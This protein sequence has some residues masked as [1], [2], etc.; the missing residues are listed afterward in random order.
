MSNDRAIPLLDRLRDSGLLQSEQLEQLG[1]L[2]ETQRKDPN[3]LGRFVYQQGWLSKYHINQIASGKGRDLSVGPYLVLDRLGE[4]GMGQVFRAQHQHMQRIVALKVIRKENLGSPDA[5]KR[6]YQEVQAAA[7]L[8]H[9][10]IV[11]AYDAGQVGNTHYFAMELVEGIDLSRLVKESGPVPLALACDYVRQ[12]AAGL[13][14]AHERCLVHRDIKPANLLLSVVNGKGTVKILDMGLARFHGGEREKGITQ[15]GQVIGTPDYLAPEQAMDSRAAD[16]RSDIYSLGCTLYYLLSARPPFT[17]ETL[18]QV[19][20]QHQ[21]DEA[22]LEKLG[23]PE[24]LQDVLGKMMA[25]KPED[26]YQTPAEVESAL[27][28]FATGEAMDASPFV[29]IT[30]AASRRKDRDETL[31]G[32]ETPARARTRKNSNSATALLPEKA[33]KKSREKGPA[34]SKQLLLWVG[35][36][37]GGVVVLLLLVLV[38]VLL[39]RPAPQPVAV[40]PNPAPATVTEGP[41]PKENVQPVPQPVQPVPQPP[42]AVNPPPVVNPLPRVP[43]SGELKRFQKTVPENRTFSVAFSLDE[44]RFVSTHIGRVIVWDI[45]SGQELRVIEGQADERFLKAVFTPDSQQVL[46]GSSRGHAGL[47]NIATGQEVKRLACPGQEVLVALSPDGRHAATG[48]DDRGQ[49]N[50]E[51]ESEARVRLWEVATGQEVA[52]T[53]KV[54]KGVRELS[55]TAD[56]KKLLFAGGQFHGNLEVASRQETVL[57]WLA[58]N[59]AEMICFSPD[60]RHALVGTPSTTLLFNLEN[61]TS[62]LKSGGSSTAAS[63]AMAPDNNRWALATCTRLARVGKTNFRL[64]LA[65]GDLTPT[66]STPSRFLG[67][68][69]VENTADQAPLVSKG[70]SLAIT[71]DCRCALLATLDGVIRLVD[72]PANMIVQNPPP[73]VPQPVLTK[74]LVPFL[75]VDEGMPVIG[76]VKNFKD[77]AHKDKVL[78]LAASPN[79]QLFVA[80]H[81]GRVVVWNI[82]SGQPVRTITGDPDEKFAS[83][84]FSADSRFILV[85]SSKGYA[86]FHPVATGA[87]GHRYDCLGQDVLVALSPDG[88]LVATAGFEAR[89]GAPIGA[90]QF[91][92]RLWTVTGQ[93]IFRSPRVTAGVRAL[94]FTSDSRR[95]LYGTATLYGILETPTRREAITNWTGVNQVRPLAFSADGLHALVCGTNAQPRLVDLKTG[96][97]GSAVLPDQ[98]MPPC[99]ALALDPAGK[100]AILGCGTTVQQNQNSWAGCK[101]R[102]FELDRTQELGQF[103]LDLV[104]MEKPRPP[105]DPFSSHLICVTLSRD[106]KQALC[107]TVDGT[108][109]LLDLSNLQDPFGKK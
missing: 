109:H 65:T 59:W 15:T 18:T 36:G 75:K 32:D 78:S 102:F 17:G 3:S 13:Q 9:P 71:K 6:F 4:G 96:V 70:I 51:V 30:E 93:E 68:I 82:A 28:P 5:V 50:R 24:G 99:Q 67:F 1:Q 100:R 29:A 81:Q 89:L 16:I 91:T 80:T 37:L 31:S 83:A 53:Q 84:V 76:E 60:G 66:G 12:A 20:I 40:V 94:A 11:V 105:F 26:R 85:G 48:G 44:K 61:Q 104:D 69:E 54:V 8:T 23:V 64:S 21:M 41:K 38:I 86:Q 42:P 79:G 95:L 62:T 52:F 19:L 72:M 73:V 2:P 45:T 27:A 87:K 39:T 34:S 46:V 55:F 103:P 63:A 106:G 22:P 43:L 92:V 90:N 25:K 10:N 74:P 33:R 88:R 49:L 98:S 107:G 47:Y 7:Q 58:P 56:S 77:P 97:A 57:P 101:V 14:H 35:G 108:I